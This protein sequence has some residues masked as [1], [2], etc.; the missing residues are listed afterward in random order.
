MSKPFAPLLACNED[1]EVQLEHIPYPCLVSPKIDGIRAL[2]RNGTMNTR[3]LKLVPN[4]YI[5]EEIEH[6]VQ[7][8]DGEL[9]IGRADSKQAFDDTG[10][11][12]RLYSE[13]D[14]YYHVFD[15]VYDDVIHLTY[16]ERLVWLTRNLPEHPRI[17][18]VNQHV[19]NN[20]EE[21]MA[22]EADYLL[23]G[24]EG[25]IA[26]D[27]NGAYKFGRSSKGDRI[28]FK[29]KRFADGE[30]K[31]VGFEERMKNE[32]EQTTNELGRS[33]RSGHRD[34]LVGRGDLGAFVVEFRG[35]VFNIGTGR[36]LD[37]H[38]RQYVWDHKEE[39]LGKMLKFKYMDIGMKVAPRSP[40]AFGI[41]MPEDM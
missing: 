26:R 20:E 17:Q 18:I 16:A 15:A 29:V 9:V 35:V 33:K 14:F 24:Y 34:G 22:L 41:R 38:W 4:R 3:S 39:Y 13:C 31:I 6:L 27:P 21:L 12:R 30:A 10:A 32:N 19:I 11:I 40:V 36:G 5:R 37:D 25:L 1:L 23:K 28:M 8:F 7:G 2:G